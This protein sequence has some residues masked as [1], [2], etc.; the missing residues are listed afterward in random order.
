[1][2]T[3]VNN[4]IQMV[5]GI[6]KAREIVSGA[7]EIGSYYIEY[8]LDTKKYYGYDDFCCAW[9]EYWDIPN[10]PMWQKIYSKEDFSFNR[11]ALKDLRTAI[12]EHDKAW[13]EKRFGIKKWYPIPEHHMCVDKRLDDMTDDCTAID[14]YD[15]CEFE[16]ND[17]VVLINKPGSSNS[18]HRVLEVRHPT[19]I[20]VC[21]IN[22]ISGNDLVV[23]QFCASPYYLKHIT[24][25]EFDAGH[26]IDEGAQR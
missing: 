7:P 10:A 12:A 5:G 20:V 25:D 19:T 11:I 9:Y 26:R 8:G 6:E 16:V 4:Q 17:Q 3:T 22:Q 23:L 14:E 21:P 15:S 13:M 24:G 2:N 18:I 1:M